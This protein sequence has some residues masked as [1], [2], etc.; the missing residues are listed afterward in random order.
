MGMVTGVPDKLTGL[1]DHVKLGISSR[2]GDETIETA[3]TAGEAYST[4]VG[5]IGQHVATSNVPILA[6]QWVVPDTG[7]PLAGYAMSTAAGI[8]VPLAQLT[9]NPITFAWT[10]ACATW[11]GVHITTQYGTG[12]VENYFYVQAPAITAFTSATGAP[13]VGPLSGGTYLRFGQAPGPGITIDATVAC[14]SDVAGSVAFI[15]LASNERF[16]IDDDGR[17]WH[18]S[19]NGQYV[20]DTGP[21]NWLF[22]QNEIVQIGAQQSG[23]IQITDAPAMELGAV[24]TL[25]AVGDG[26]PIVPETYRAYLMFLPAAVPALWVALGVLTWNWEGFTQFENGGWGPVQQPGNLVN[27]AGA[28]GTALP[29]WSSNTAAGAWVQG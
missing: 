10:A 18:W 2:F 11:V 14:P 22:Y 13:W 9:V 28:A 27:P 23:Q 12:Y 20:L 21:I 16:V 3:A 7:A 4:V 17:S 6:V 19:S 29:T 25:A 15:Q 26:Q 24:L 5:A 1:P 8:L